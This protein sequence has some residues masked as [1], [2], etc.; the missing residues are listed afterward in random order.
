MALNSSPRH[1]LDPIALL[2]TLPCTPDGRRA[3]TATSEPE[4]LPEEG[5]YFVEQESP[6]FLCKP[7]RRVM[8]M[9]KCLADYMNANAMDKKRSVCWRCSFG[10]KNRVAYSEE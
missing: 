8:R 3:A 9:E 6:M 7:R 4:V 5:M 2:P 10:R 1:P